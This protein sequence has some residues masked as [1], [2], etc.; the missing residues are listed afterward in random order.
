MRQ[1]D[2]TIRALCLLCVIGLC[3][4]CCT[5]PDL[6]S[7]RG[8]VHTEVPTGS[9]ELDVQRFCQRHRFNYRQGNQGEGWARLEHHCLLVVPEDIVARIVYDE[10]GRVQS[11]E[12]KIDNM[13]P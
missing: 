12:V 6:E 9:S 11:T 13:L 10:A 7:A 4:G 5:G 8:W 2:I 3:G 1:I